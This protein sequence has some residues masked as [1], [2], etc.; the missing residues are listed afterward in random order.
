MKYE[1]M[2]MRHAVEMIDEKKLLLPHIQRPFVWKYDQ[3]KGFFDSIMREYPI[4]TLL[5]W[6]TREEVQIR[7]FIDNYVEGMNVKETYLKTSEYNNKE[8]WLVLDGQQ[9]LQA[10]YI[11]LKGTYNGRELYFDLLSG[12]NTVIDGK[13]ELKYLVEY[14]TKEEADTQN[15]SKEHYWFLLKSIVLSDES[16]TEIKRTI[17]KG[18]GWT[19]EETKAVEEIVDD[20]VGKIK[21][22]FSALE[23]IFYYP[24]DSVANKYTYDEVLEIFVRS[25]SGGTMLSKSDL[26]FSLIKLNWD[27][28]E[29]NF[30]NLLSS[31]NRQGTFFFDKDFILKTALVWSGRGAKYE[32]AK[33]KGIEGEKTLEYIKDIWPKF[34]ASFR[35]LQDFL[36][37][38]RIT[39][40][41]ILPS[42]NALI[43]IIV[44]AGIHDCKVNSPKLK[45]NMQTWLYKTLLNGNFSGQADRVIDNTKVV[46][47][48]NPNP[49]Y[50]PYKEL[51]DVMVKLKRNVAVDQYT[52]DSHDHLILNLL[53]LFSNKTMNFQPTLVCNSPEIDHIFPRSKMT[54]KYKYPS[55]MVNNIGN[56]MFLEKTLN[57]QKTAIMPEEYFPQAIAEQPDFLKRNCIPENPE[58]HKPENFERFVNTRRKM[59]YDIVREILVY[60][61]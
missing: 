1:S 17:L 12:R 32:V 5:F 29:E 26:M 23:L 10:L 22:L 2:S 24:I 51:E 41:A 48:T 8:K 37:Y 11:A 14:M 58:L 55:A 34:E 19:T 60:R 50:F 9:R 40:A 27:N 39:S 46:L 16:P 36:D 15:K 47:M 45:Y 56:Y 52:I 54:N 35:W 21:N 31:M 43:P 4:N 6:R 28:A 57:I 44:F 38:S 30:E 61:E 18:M 3:V 33:F 7:K 25:N 42:Y 13:N 53:Y 20:N 59:I 49:D